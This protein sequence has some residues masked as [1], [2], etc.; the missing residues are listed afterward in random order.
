MKAAGNNKWHRLSEQFWRQSKST[1]LCFIEINHNTR[2]CFCRI[3]GT[4]K[5]FS[6][7]KVVSDFSFNWLVS[8]ETF[9]E[10]NYFKYFQSVTKA[11]DIHLFFNH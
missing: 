6:A 3:F 10:D 8:K 5:P 7:L 4:V 9:F 11:G 2:R 1:T